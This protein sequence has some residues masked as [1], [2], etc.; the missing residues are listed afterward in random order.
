MIKEP[1]ISPQLEVI[2][3][4]LGGIIA[5]SPVPDAEWFGGEEIWASPSSEE[6][7]L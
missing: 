5:S 1:Y 7:F 2:E 3:L 6:L 4:T